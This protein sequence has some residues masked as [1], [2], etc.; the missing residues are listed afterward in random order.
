MSETEGPRVEKVEERE[1]AR[2][3]ALG[4]SELSYPQLRARAVRHAQ[5]ARAAPPVANQPWTCIGP[6][7][8]AGRILALAQDPNDPQV[9]YAGSA[10]GG[11]WRTG[12]AGDT[13]THL[14]L[15]EHNFPVGA[16]A[17]HPSRPGLL[18]VGTGSIKPNHGSGQGLFRVEV[19]LVRGTPVF[20]PINAPLRVATYVQLA[21]APPP[22]Q[23]P[24]A[25]TNGAAL[26]YSRIEVDPDDPDRFWV[27]SQTG[28]WR[29][30]VAGTPPVAA[31]QRDFPPP[32]GAPLAASAPALA[33]LPLPRTGHWP[34]Y[35]TDLRVLR[36]ARDTEHI[37]DA[38]GRRVQR[39]LVLYVAIEGVGVFRG[40]YDRSQGDSAAA[41]VWEKQLPVPLNGL[42]VTRTIIAVCRNRPEHVYVVYANNTGFGTAEHEHATFVFRSTDH[43]E[44]WQ[45]RGRIPRGYGLSDDAATGV[46]IGG[47]ADYDLVLEVNPDD[48][49]VLV[50]GEVDL[51]RS[52]DAGNTWI[53]I[54][55]WQLYD[56]G[57]YG[58]H[59][60]QHAALFDAFDRK[61]LWVGNDG[62]LVMARDLHAEAASRGY[63]RRRSAGIIA[64]QFQ[65]VTVHPNPAFS[66]IAGGGLQDNGSWVSY[67]G[68]TWYR[69]GGG[70][71][72]MM[73]IHA[74]NPRQYLAGAQ[75]DNEVVRVLGAAAGGSPVNPVVNDLGV[76]NGLMFTGRFNHGALAFAN[77]GAGP[78]VPVQEQDPTN[79]GQVLVGWTMVAGGAVAYHSSPGGPIALPAPAVTVAEEASAVA[80][81]PVPV[82]PATLTGWI[83]LSDGRV[84][85]S[86][87]APAGA[88]VES[89]SFPRTLGRLREITRFAVHP[90]VPAMVAVAS[91]IS[92][93]P[94]Q[95]TITAA[96]APGTATYDVQYW[97]GAGGGSFS[98]VVPAGPTPAAGTS[99]AIPGTDILAQ[100]PSPA[101]AV[102]DSWIVQVDG[103][104][105]P[106]VPALAGGLRTL[107]TEGRVLTITIAAP[108]IPGVATFTCRIGAFVATAALPTAA[109]VEV[110]GTETVLSFSGG[111]FVA[112]HA[113][114]V[115]T[116][117]TVNPVGAVAGTVRVAARLHGR[118][119]LTY[120]G[121]ATWADI[122]CPTT[123]PAAPADA[124]S[125]SLPPCSATSLAFDIDGAGNLA[126]YCGT[127][128]GVFVFH[129]VPAPPAAPPLPVVNAAWRPFNGT[130]GQPFPLTLVTDLERFTIPAA[131]APRR[132]LRA[133]TFGRGI[134]DCELTGA[135]QFQP[136]IRQLLIED[137]R[138]YPRTI[139]PTAAPGFAGADSDYRV[140][141]GL[142][143]YDFTHA[144]DIRVD[145]AP[146]HFFEDRVDGVEFDED[147]GADTLVPLATN[148][149]YVQVHNSGFD[150][151]GNVTVHLY[152]APSGPAPL[153]PPPGSPVPAGLPP[154]A[155]FWDQPG[156]NPPAASALQRVGPP[157]GINRIAPDAPVVVRFDWAPPATLAGGN[158]ALLAVCSSPQSPLPAR[159]AAVVSLRDVVVNEPRAALRVVPVGPVPAAT[160]YVREGVDDDGRLGAVAH[161]GRSPD[162]IVV[163]AEPPE[164]PAAA[165]K[166]LLDLRPQ[167]RMRRN[168]TN[169]IYVRLFNRGPVAVNTEVHLFAAAVD[170]AGQPATAPASWTRLTPDPANPAPP[171]L[172]VAVPPGGVAYALQTWANPPDPNPADELKAWALIALI[173]DADTAGTT[174]PDTSRVTDAAS[175]EQL[176]SGFFD[177]S[178]AA[179]RVLRY[180]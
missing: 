129:N 140:P 36:D 109:A 98:A 154:A 131:P 165:F 137:G 70:D 4:V 95:I 92:A 144:F 130:L 76:Q 119:H 7:N 56:D 90:T 169:R 138:R 61:R 79:P 69:I 127:L 135:P 134:W 8:V 80:F 153:V 97:Q 46:F 145:S 132:F 126:L 23:S 162:I 113:W 180:D 148:A 94:V 81:G 96:G 143:G 45:Q 159:P 114:T 88:W 42:N 168:L 171:Q 170:A 84:F 147:L 100:F 9:L 142:V 120:D 151:L 87:N 41:V 65:D 122:S 71:G 136:F 10:H 49:D 64:G 93:R 67:G 40:R 52:E 54:L 47:Q 35:A 108:G 78:F 5:L 166:D 68:P 105:N 161:A 86:A 121:G 27:A 77:P 133:A 66:F 115:A 172:R 30:K 125:A 16:I 24:G 73:A 74:T 26:R 18:W 20:D 156:L 104:I 63:W 160:V 83:G 38:N 51:C 175:F 111:P 106:G 34:A 158:V 19:P 15:A 163:P 85:S 102:G 33:G 55:T 91:I 43:G 58:Q 39:F 110:P 53:P 59:G 150:I 124:R 99:A 174:V 6:R 155:D 82:A 141:A 37:T 14:G 31:W 117:D 57:D 1:V 178:H 107:V 12:D 60:D 62:G 179:L 118:V 112:G 103:T 50:C 176:F 72:G 13:W 177:A 152:F 11:L 123:P 89:V 25:A 164:P 116:D 128:V 75:N 21:S 146:L 22:E 167:D 3:R 173:R 149:V 48:P 32:A 101:Y 44:N 2:R 157:K 29:A 139:P 17:L 28:L